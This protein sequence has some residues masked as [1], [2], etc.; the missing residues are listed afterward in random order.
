MIY[1]ALTT[2]A[3]V[4]GGGTRRPPLQ[5]DNVDQR[6]SRKWICIFNY[7]PLQMT[8]NE[9][10]T[11]NCGCGGNDWEEITWFICNIGTHLIKFCNVITGID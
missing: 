9:R 5:V 4:F 6:V 10:K 8:E 3:N 1:R 2:V 11:L 7:L